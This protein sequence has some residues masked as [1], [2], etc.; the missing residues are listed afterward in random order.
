M[1]RLVRFAAFLLLSAI[2]LAA[3]A[4]EPIKRMYVFGDSYSDI[5]RGFLDSDGPTAVA[6]MAQRLGLS[7]VA[8]NAPDSK[9]KSLNFAVSGAPTG[10]APGRTIP[11]GFIGLGMKEEVDEFVAMV[12]SGA[13]TFDP[14]TTLF[15]LAGGLNDAL[16]PGDAT[17][18]HLEAEIETLYAAGARRFAVATLPETIRGFAGTGVRLNPYLVKIPDE[19][20]PRLKGGEISTSHWGAFFDAVMREPAKYGITDTRTA[21][22]TQAP[23]AKPCDSP[24]THYFYFPAHPSTAVH[25]AVGDMLYD[26][27]TGKPLPQ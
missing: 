18:A 2:T 16:I 3:H 4:A 20:R 19:M 26:E 9:G 10:S 24:A 12:K 11:N 1:P 7:M 14:K 6:Y 8:S 25:K 21:C 13:V 17:V 27:A 15:Y 22:M 5:G 23:D